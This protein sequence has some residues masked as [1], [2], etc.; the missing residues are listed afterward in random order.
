MAEAPMD[1]ITKRDNNANPVSSGQRLRSYVG[2]DSTP[3][4]FGLNQLGHPLG[5][6]AYLLKQ[7]S[8]HKLTAK[9]PRKKSLVA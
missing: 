9:N 8:I 2:I 1:D 6:V 4:V 3:I 5:E 7:G